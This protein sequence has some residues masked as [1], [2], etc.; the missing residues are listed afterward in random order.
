MKKRILIVTGTVVVAFS[1]III[2]LPLSKYLGFEINEMAAA[3]FSPSTA[4]VSMFLLLTALYF[5]VVYSSQRFLHKSPFK[6]LGFKKPVISHILIAFVIGIVINLVPFVITILT[7]KN[8][9]YA[10]AIPEGVSLLRVAIGYFFFFFIWLTVNSIGEE[11]VFRSYPIEQFA[12]KPRALPFVVLS[13]AIVFA[14]LHFIVREPSLNGFFMLSITSIFYSLIYL[15]WR[16]IWVLVGIHN[17][18]NF[19]NLTFSE[20]WEMGGLFTWNGEGMAGLDVYLN[21]YHFA[22]PI[23]AIAFLFRR[24]LRSQSSLTISPRSKT[25]QQKV[26]A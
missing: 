16:S 4:K 14:L 2:G 24:H 13:A 9:V 19:I 12:D 15:N 25:E 18:M 23:V 10:S 3:G 8:M 6:V 5:A 11:L 20:N 22:V 26:P 1:M 17:G 21:V 7:A